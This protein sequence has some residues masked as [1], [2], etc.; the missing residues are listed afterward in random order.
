MPWT[1][2]ELGKFRGKGKTL[3]QILFKDPDWFFW[4]WE[5]G[6]FA[7]PAAV[8]EEASRI[9]A[10]ARTIRIPPQRGSTAPSAV[11]Y[12]FDSRT[13]DF[14]NLQIVPASRSASVG[15]TPTYR[16]DCF[17]LSIPRQQRNYDK[18]GYKGFL[19]SLKFALFGD[20]S[21]RMTRERCEAFFDNP[22]NFL[23]NGPAVAPEENPPECTE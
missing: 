12:R 22:D 7:N 8:F 3:P 21:A 6:C 19:S 1:P 10:K 5:N 20:A 14:V 4:A 13:G 9:Q 16:T 23:N 2:V 15:T 18:G 17:D 11:E